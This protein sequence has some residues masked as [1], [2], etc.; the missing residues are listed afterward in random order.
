MKF[1]AK[2]EKLEKG[3]NVTVY[4]STL[5]EA[6]ALITELFKVARSQEETEND[7]PIAA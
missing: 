1:K 7:D 4:R 6:N 2:L 5:T 3:W